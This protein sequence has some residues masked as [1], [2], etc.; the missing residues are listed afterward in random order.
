MFDRL[1]L[2]L[3]FGPPLWWYFYS[4]NMTTSVD[5]PVVLLPPLNPAIFAKAGLAIGLGV[6]INSGLKLDDAVFMLVL[7]LSTLIGPL[8]LPTRD[9]PSHLADHLLSFS[10]LW[11]VSRLRTAALTLLAGVFFWIAVKIWEF[12]ADWL[13]VP[14]LTG[15]YEQLR[16][17]A[18]LVDG[19]TNHVMVPGEFY[20]TAILV[21]LVKCTL[22]AGL[23]APTPI[24]GHAAPI[25]TMIVGLCVLTYFHNISLFIPESMGGW[26]A[27]TVTGILGAAAISLY[28]SWFWANA[29][30]KLPSIIDTVE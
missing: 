30:A 6:A 17:R 20:L 11:F 26:D 1:L 5:R 2:V 14:T 10:F 9:P 29:Q 15:F 7:I 22:L 23:K 3:V 16:D 25:V 28:S 21:L 12:V 19:I 8:T 24:V 4:M 27:P 13:Q 18:S